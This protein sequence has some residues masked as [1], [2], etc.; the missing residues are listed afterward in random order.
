MTIFIIFGI[1]MVSYAKERDVTVAEG[2]DPSDLVQSVIP[3]FD[4]IRQ[5]PEYQG[6]FFE[7]VKVAPNK[8]TQRMECHTDPYLKDYYSD[9]PRIALI[10]NSTESETTPML[11]E[12]FERR[13][14]KVDCYLAC[15]AGEKAGSGIDSAKR[16]YVSVEK[17]GIYSS[18]DDLEA[19][20]KFGVFDKTVADVYDHDTGTYTDVEFRYKGILPKLDDDSY[21]AVV[22]AG[23]DKDVIDMKRQQWG[24]DEMDFL[25]NVK[26]PVLALC[27]GH[28]ILAT[29]F[30]RQVTDDKDVVKDVQELIEEREDYLEHNKDDDDKQAIFFNNF[31]KNYDGGKSRD[32][33]PNLIEIDRKN[34][35]FYGMPKYAFFGEEHGDH[36]EISGDLAQLMDENNVHI[37]K[38]AHSGTCLTEGLFYNQVIDGSEVPKW[39]SQAHF[40]WGEMLKNHGFSNRPGYKALDNFINIIRFFKEN[41]TLNGYKGFYLDQNQHKLAFKQFEKEYGEIVDDDAEIS[42][43]ETDYLNYLASFFE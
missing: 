12:Y 4:H 38:I 41:Q 24:K 6:Q 15:A 26:K 20:V 9:N 39:G 30:S 36:V 37:Q 1:N 34:P 17:D 11:K 13:G 14:A 5:V 3:F 18:K 29:S 31:L 40:E 23:G 25:Y 43:D 42:L 27:L 8:L 21:D 28:Q 7:K 2:K 35:L 10:V 33:G 16:G 22:V 32:V 19:A